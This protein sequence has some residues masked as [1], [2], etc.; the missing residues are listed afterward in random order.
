MTA[1]TKPDPSI[2]R[3]RVAAGQDLTYEQYSRIVFDRVWETKQKE[4]NPNTR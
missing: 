1:Q 3:V 2:Y 4:E